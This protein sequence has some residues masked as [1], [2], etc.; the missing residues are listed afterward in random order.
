MSFLRARAAPTLRRSFATTAGPVEAAGVKVLGIENGLRPATSSVTVVVKG[1]SRFEPSSGA[2]HVLKNF[3]FKVRVCPHR[4][5]QT[6][7][8]LSRKCSDTTGG[9]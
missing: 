6:E 9:K 5:W 4:T 3:A 1:G 8:I 7:P 2:A